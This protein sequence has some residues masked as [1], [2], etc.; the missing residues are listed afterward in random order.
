[1]PTQMGEFDF[2][3]VLISLIIGLGITNLLSGAGR[4]FYRRRRNP[5][6]EVHMVLT[7][8]T[9]LILVLNWW[10]SFSWRNETNWSYEEFLVL[11]I[12][13]ISLYMIT[14][15]L[16]SICPKRSQNRRDAFIYWIR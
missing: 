12:W 15:F 2:I 11:I 8:A 14:I 10:V 7:V 16:Y 4:V 1:M 9:L 13:T 3:S 6:D 5:I